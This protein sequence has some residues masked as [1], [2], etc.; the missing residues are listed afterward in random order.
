MSLKQIFAEGKKER[1]RRKSLNRGQGDLK[2]KQEALAGRLTDLGR[3]AWVEKSALSAFP[4]L[5]SALE[6]QQAEIDGLTQSINDASKRREE[7]EGAKKLEG[8]RFDTERLAVE[9][10]KKETDGRLNAEKDL[11]KTLQKSLSQ[12]ESRSAQIHKERDQLHKKITDPATAAEDKASGE[13]S[14]QELGTEEAGLLETRKNQGE[15]IKAQTDKIAP[16]QAE[17]DTLQKQIKDI[18]AGQKASMGEFD[19]ALGEI[20]KEIDGLQAK[21]KEA[22]KA[23]AESFRSL[24]EGL[25]AGS[26]PAPCLNTELEAVKEAEREVGEI[27]ARLSDLG[28]QGS[29]EAASAYKKMMTIL[30]GGVLL[31]VALIVLA[32]I[33]F[34]PKKKTILEEL[35]EGRIPA[36]ALAGAMAEVS[37]GSNREAAQ[38]DAEN[39]QDGLDAIKEASEKKIGSGT[40]VAGEKELSAV[41]NPVPGWERS[42]PVYGRVD[43]SGIDSASSRSVYRDSD[44]REVEVEVTDTH[45]AAALLAPSQALL[46]MNMTID[47]AQIY[48]KTGKLGGT[49]MIESLDKQEGVARIVLIFKDRY[50]V[51]LQTT[52]E[53]GL[54]LLRE[55]AGRLNL[56]A[57]D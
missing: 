11:L 29:P 8:E 54:D 55:F 42:D 22:E 31:I 57:L 16:L 33:L 21:M 38:A 6:T 23:Q 9:D 2:A 14:L 35:A 50:L 3:R 46:S 40:E 44:G 53:K 30:V 37:G 12:S 17:S 39:L 47:D 51:N 45:S 5:K 48:Q 19:K 52:G 56:K 15:S 18:L 20:G 24:G 4:E 7:K 36:K 34:A 25:A 27:K 10:K 13:K 43:F 49:P 26:S 1:I 28:S 32:V 41:L